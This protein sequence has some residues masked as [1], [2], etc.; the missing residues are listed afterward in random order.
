MDFTTGQPTKAEIWNLVPWGGLEGG[1]DGK[2][3]IEKGKSKLS[4]YI[5][6]MIR[7]RRSKFVPCDSKGHNCHTGGSFGKLNFNSV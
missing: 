6:K 2:P 5:E 3:G 7:K 1:T 4:S